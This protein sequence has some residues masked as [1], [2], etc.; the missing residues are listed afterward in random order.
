MLDKTLLAFFLGLFKAIA[1]RFETR[2]TGS[3]ATSNLP[4]LRRA[5][6]RIRNWMRGKQDDIRSRGESNES[7]STK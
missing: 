2:S 1:E 3:D 4:L 6:R 5:G 7:G